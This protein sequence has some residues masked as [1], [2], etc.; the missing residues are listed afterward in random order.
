MSDPIIPMA[1]M[2]AGA[3]GAGFGACWLWQMRPSL[4]REYARSELIGEL[5][6]D[7]ALLRRECLRLAVKLRPFERRRGARGRFVSRKASAQSRSPADIYDDVLPCPAK[8]PWAAAV[9]HS[10]VASC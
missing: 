7:I 9:T 8:T 6:G 4:E 1:M 3:F 5:N 10:E 2:T